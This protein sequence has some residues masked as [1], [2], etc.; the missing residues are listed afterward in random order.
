MSAN[1]GAAHW[2]KLK[3]EMEREKASR[4]FVRAVHLAVQHRL[5]DPKEIHQLQMA[6]LDQFISEFY[7]FMGA[8]KLIDDYSLGDEEVQEVIRNILARPGISDV[9]AT[10]AWYPGVVHNEPLKDLMRKFS[11]RY[12]EITKRLPQV[13]LQTAP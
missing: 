2:D 8:T 7:N 1:S 12:R 13:R 10:I 6:A 4:N 5:A 3:A 9:K 11:L